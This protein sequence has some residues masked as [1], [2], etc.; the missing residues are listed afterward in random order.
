MERND[1]LIKLVKLLLLSLMFFSC[2]TTRKTRTAHLVERLFLERERVTVSYPGGNTSEDGR[3]LGEQVIYTRVEDLGSSKSVSRLDTNEVYKL[4]EVNVTSKARFTSVR[5][6]YV[7][8]DFVIRVPKQYLLSDYQLSLTPEL[9]QGDS[10]VHLNDVVLRGENFVKKQEADY[11]EYEKYLSTVVSADSYDTVFVDRTRLNK[12]LENRRKAGMNSYYNRWV[13]VND[14]W[15]WR[16]AAEEEYIRYNTMKEY[17]Q[18]TALAY[19]RKKYEKKL[20][21]YL[22][23]E[24]DTAGLL[25]SF[26]WKFDRVREQYSGRKEITPAT[27]PFRFREVHALGLRPE[28]VQPDIPLDEDSIRLVQEYLQQDRIVMNDL[29]ESRKGEMFRK[30]VPYPYRPDAH[31]SLVL[32]EARVFNYRYTER[33]PVSAGVRRIHLTLKGTV[34]ATD[35]S[36]FKLRTD[37]LSY[38]I[39]SLDEL[40]DP[41]LA[42][43]ETFTDEE[44]KNYSAALSFLRGREYEQALKILEP[45]SDYN[46]VVALACQGGNKK[47]FQLLSQLEVTPKTLYIASILAYRLRDEQAAIEMLRR[48]CKLDESLTFRARIDSETSDLIRRYK[49]NL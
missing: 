1:W 37:T 5:E 7:D 38:I 15:K 23:A 6:G 41:F 47:A 29:K 22:K 24:K 3:V 2:S 20:S 12:E 8:I 32:P 4:P 25:H 34:V 44:R 26:Q 48:A 10:L 17:N 11:R 43:N 27:V 14:Y 42:D 46:T 30:L 45:Y 16:N 19:Y 36:L 9:I 39:S 31:Y 28:D 49:L 21:R 35:H 33:Y 18:E 40:V 13:L